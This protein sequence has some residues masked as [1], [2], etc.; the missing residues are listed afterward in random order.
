[1][2]GLIDLYRFLLSP[3]IGQ[4]CRFD[5]TCSRY[6]REAVLTHGPTRGMWLSLRRLARCHP[7][8]A[9]GHDPVPL[10]ATTDRLTDSP[11]SEIPR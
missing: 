9:G 3:W 4:H 6:A 11:S 10:A 1:M 2:V 7:W 8:H 5:P